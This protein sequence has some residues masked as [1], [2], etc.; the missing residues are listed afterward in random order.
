[1]GILTLF[2]I[3]EETI[4]SFSQLSMLAVN[5][6]YMTFIMLRNVPSILTLLS[7][8]H[9]WTLNLSNAFFCIYQGEHTIR[10]FEF[11][12]QSSTFKVWLLISTYLK[13]QIHIISFAL[14]AN[15]LITYIS[16]KSK[17]FVHIENPKHVSF[18]VCRLKKA[19]WECGN[20]LLLL[21]LFIFNNA[22]QRPL[23]KP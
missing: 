2:L 11:I 10:S 22:P 12:I 1:M 15:V 6:S 18:I 21:L 20:P 13:Y 9:K 23:I 3:L 5:L 17:N 14:N 4:S 7:L 16:K 8:Y 19:S